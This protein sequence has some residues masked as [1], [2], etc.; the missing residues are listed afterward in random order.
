[1]FFHIYVID[2][3]DNDSNSENDDDGVVDPKKVLPC[4]TSTE[5]ERIS[6]SYL[7]VIHVK[8]QLPST[9][10]NVCENILFLMFPV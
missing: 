5:S 7:T 6:F 1:M 2:D 8:C 9:A 3:D 10:T 4:E